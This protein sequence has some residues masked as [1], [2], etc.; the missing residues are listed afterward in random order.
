M[1]TEQETI[2]SIYFIEQ[3]HRQRA[4]LKHLCPCVLLRPINWN[5]DQNLGRICNRRRYCFW[6]DTF[7]FLFIHILNAKKTAS[8]FFL[9]TTSSWIP[10]S[11]FLTNDK[12]CFCP[13]KFYFLHVLWFVSAPVFFL[14]FSWSLIII[15][16]FF[17][18]IVNVTLD[19]FL[20]IELLLP[21]STACPFKITI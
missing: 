18:K 6:T 1:T 11:S 13:V 5:L 16:S 21:A 9:M 14:C 17:N 3:Y 15:L 8:I 4:P 2:R 12:I 19:A 20:V 7:F 10:N